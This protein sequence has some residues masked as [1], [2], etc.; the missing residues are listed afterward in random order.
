MYGIALKGLSLCQWRCVWHNMRTCNN[1][2][3]RQLHVSGH[4]F[5]LM[6]GRLPLLAGWIHVPGQLQSGD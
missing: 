2:A 6:C 1:E 4:L 5:P 3:L